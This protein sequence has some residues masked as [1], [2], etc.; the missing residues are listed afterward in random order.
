MTSVPATDP[1]TA[2]PRPVVAERDWAARLQRPLAIA[3]TGVLA[4]GLV[5]AAPNVVGRSSRSGG[6]APRPPIS[7]AAPPVN[8]PAVVDVVRSSSTVAFDT[9][10]SVVLEAATSDAADDQLRLPG[11]PEPAVARTPG[12]DGGAPVAPQPRPGRGPDSPGAEP[13][14]E[15]IV[16]V[17]ATA[18]PVDGGAQLDDQCS[19]GRLAGTAFGD[20][21]PEAVAAETAGIELA[22]PV[23]T[24]VLG[25]PRTSVTV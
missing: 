17:A 16:L 1:A 20:C 18:G 23:L 6:V 19:G 22:S 7:Q 8:T 2:A 3:T 14:S 25:S 11:S 4:I 10:I 9:A 21:A 15:P 13:V 24:P 5:A 12:D